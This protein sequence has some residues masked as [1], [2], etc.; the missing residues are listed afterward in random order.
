M[1]EELQRNAPE[2][3]GRIRTG[4]KGTLRQGEALQNQGGMGV[5][6]I[7]CSGSGAQS[8]KLHIPT[9]SPDTPESFGPARSQ[10]DP[11][12]V[13]SQSCA[14]V[15]CCMSASRGDIWL[16]MGTSCFEHGIPHG[17]SYTSAFALDCHHPSGWLDT[18]GLWLLDWAKHSRLT[19]AVFPTHKLSG[20][21][22][23]RWIRAHHHLPCQELKP[24][25]CDCLP[26]SKPIQQGA[27]RPNLPR[28]RKPNSDLS[29]IDESLPTRLLSY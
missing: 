15:L 29:S 20:H 7:C 8:F 10:D 2:G 6:W 12:R 25:G 1:Q 28:S 26:D 18:T 27:G 23:V 13:T 17:L 16:L 21:L 22:C 3:P 24:P 9:N 14:C 4:E 5:Q 11:N 19:L